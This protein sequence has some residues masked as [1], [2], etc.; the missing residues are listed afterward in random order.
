MGVRIK[1]RS[2]WGAPS[3]S[4]LV[5]EFAQD[6]IVVGRGRSADVLL[7]NTAVSATHATI[8][9]HEVG[10]AITDEGSTN[11]T[12][13]NEALLA[14]GRPKILRTGDRIELGGYRLD[15]ELGIPVSQMVSAR[16]S[17]SYAAAMLETERQGLDAQAALDELRRIQ[18]ESDRKV[19]LLPIA[20][21]PPPEPAQRPSRPP[22]PIPA[23]PA[24]TKHSRSELGVY[25]MAAV[26]VS[27]CGLALYFLLQAS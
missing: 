27:A 11:G 13:I 23:A 25:A 12:R 1:V 10:Y 9:T 3:S 16:L 14:V 15:V 6:R 26:L 18:G 7:P 5:Y 20:D 2:L 4:V 8:R 24:P 21:E 19:E 22:T 17:M